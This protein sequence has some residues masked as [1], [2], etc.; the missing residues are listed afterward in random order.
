MTEDNLIYHEYIN[1]QKKFE[2]KYGQKTI[3]LMQVGAFF[4]CYGIKN[5][6]IK[7][8]KVEEVAD[9][10][11]ILVTKKNKSKKEI[12][13]HN[14]IM[15]GFQTPYTNKYI[16]LLLDEN[17]T[18]ILVE[19][20]TQPPNPKREVTEIISPGV[21]LD[22]YKK[23]RDSNF[24]M[25]I[26][27]EELQSRKELKTEY[28]V[29]I[30][31]ID[32]SIGKS[33]IYETGNRNTDDYNLALD[34]I[35]RFIQT[36]YPRE[37]IFH[38]INVSKSK[39]D[40][41]EYIEIDEKYVHYF[42]NTLPKKYTKPSYQ[43]EFLKKVYPNTGFLSPIEFIDMEKKSLALISFIILLEFANEHNENIITQLEKPIIQET[44]QHLILATNS[45]QQLNL[46]E[47]SGIN[48]NTKFKSLF[49]VIN[50]ASTALGRRLIKE[51]MLSPIINI[52]ELNERYDIVDVFKDNYL[53]YEELLKPILD[54]DR[55]HRRLVLKKLHP[56]E[57]YQLHICYQNIVNIINKVKKNNILKKILPDEKILIEFNNFIKEYNSKY[58]LNRMNNKRIEELT[59]N[60][61]KLN[62][63]KKIDDTQL[64]IDNININYNC[65]MD[66][67]NILCECKNYIK[68]GN[69][70][71]DGHYLQLTKT[72]YKNLKKTIEDNDIK[73]FN[74]KNNENININEIKIKNTSS[75]TRLLLVKWSKDLINLYEIIKNQNRNYYLTDLEYFTNKYI[76]TLQKI[77]NFISILDMFK[78]FGK[79]TKLNRYIRPKIIGNKSFIEA[80]D[81]RHPIIEKIN[82]DYEYVS[83][84]ICLGKNKEDGIL[85]YGVNA[86]GK[87]SLMKSVGLNIILA[88]MGMF[89]PCKEMSYYPFEYILTR[90]CG[91]DNIFKGQSS[92]AVEMEE[93]RGILLRAKEN[94]LVLGDEI[95]S[96][97]EYISAQSIIA[98]SLKRLYKNGSKYIFATH[99]HGLTKM[100][101]IQQ[102][103]T[104]KEYHLSVEYK[105][106]KLYYIR[107]LKEGSGDNIYGLEVAKAMGFDNDF[108]DDAYKIRNKIINKK[109]ILQDNKSKYN[110]KVF[111]D[112]CEICNK[113]N[114]LHTHH[115]KFQCS[116]DKEGYIDAYHKNRESNLVI[117][118]ENC[119]QK[120]HNYVN[121]EKI[122]IDGYIKT[123]EGKQLEYKFIHKKD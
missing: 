43:N 62:I 105:N 87:S 21:N 91:N 67:L 59:D 77:S 65:L 81:M 26:Y 30:S 36:Y 88:Q 112:H 61:Y 24:I 72:R 49:H 85:L 64:K 118:C 58:N 69:T 52:K 100:N 119:H 31:V 68:R 32:L 33:Y 27:F 73:Y 104:L 84:N 106:N 10:M 70:S 45:I 60:I 93:L 6:D 120:V 54:L 16:P 82:T 5:N 12:N 83:N 92:F 8:G 17:Y 94:S 40:I 57:F 71:E 75:C 114:N 37:I 42:E 99:L 86:S 113:K 28:C 44:V 47:T 25:G 110:N 7:E 50:N 108:M 3:V 121:N 51:T 98:A 53:D 66:K 39:E 107:K 55:L 38:C 89:V 109:E 80:K 116:A 14:P 15:C 96:G 103:K 9:V 4:E 102:I 11:N 111:V 79:T 115:I 48:I 29:G 117:L 101:D 46:I 18:I 2:K 97:T 13:I 123:N 122:I 74:L 20:V 76:S 23:T 41:L 22:Y 19:Q 34:E 1:Y 63:N 95:C 56:M 78:S 35:F 90:I